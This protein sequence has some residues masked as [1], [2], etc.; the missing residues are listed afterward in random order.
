MDG[1]AASGNINQEVT[2]ERLKQKVFIDEFFDP[3]ARDILPKD[4]IKTYDIKNHQYNEKF[5]QGLF[6]RSESTL[7]I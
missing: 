3:I 6:K 7:P 1:N 2:V 4:G 5:L